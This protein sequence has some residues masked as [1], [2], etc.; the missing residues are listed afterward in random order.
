M[1]LVIVLLMGV[2]ISLVNVP[3]GTVLARNVDKN[4]LGKVQSLINIGSQGLTPLASFLGGLVIQSAGNSV[5]LFGCSPLSLQYS[6]KIG[7]NQYSFSGIEGGID[8]DISLD[9]KD[10][11]NDVKLYNAISSSNN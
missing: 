2:V 7:D 1:F 3:L 9:Y 5:L 4:M 10:F 8:V 6:E 11:Y